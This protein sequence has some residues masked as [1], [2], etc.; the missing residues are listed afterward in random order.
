MIDERLVFPNLEVSDFKSSVETMGS[1][2]KDLGYVE[3]SFVDAVLNREVSFPTGL[4]LGTYSIAIPHTDPEHVKKSGISI[5]TL[6][7]PVEV[8]SMIDPQ[9]TIKVSFIVLMAIKDP[10]GQLKMLSKLMGFFQDVDTLKMLG[11]AEE[12]EE[13]LSIIDGLELSSC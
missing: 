2:M 9:K 1:N 4:E 3:S 6:N 5:A 7:Q 13:I 11:E 12:K 8:K 10:K